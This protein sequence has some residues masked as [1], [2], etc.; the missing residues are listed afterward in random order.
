MILQANYLDIME[1][2]DAK[3]DREQDRLATWEQHQKDKFARLQTLLSQYS[4]TQ[5]QLQSQLAQ[6]SGGS[7]S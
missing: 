3:I 6:L 5:A 4:K 7:G 1:S 2:I